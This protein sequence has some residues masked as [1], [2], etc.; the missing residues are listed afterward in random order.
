MVRDFWQIGHTLSLGFM[1]APQLGHLLFFF[2][3]W[4]P[5][6]SLIILPSLRS[7]IRSVW[8]AAWLSWV[9]M[10]M[11]V[12]C[13]RLRLARSLMISCLFWLSRFPVGSSARMNAGLFAK[14]RAMATRCCSPALRRWGRWFSL[15][16]KP[17]HRQKFTCAFFAFSFGFDFAFH[18]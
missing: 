13:V 12:P 7:S 9:T 6:F 16:D 4:S 3:R 1:S 11:V 18:G 14:A 5:S 8:L 10:M 17:N 2:A 15:P